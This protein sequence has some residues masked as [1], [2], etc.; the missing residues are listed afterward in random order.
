LPASSLGVKLLSFFIGCVHFR[1]PT[2]SSLL[3]NGFNPGV[4]LSKFNIISD[5]PIQPRDMQWQYFVEA[6]S[7]KPEG[8]GFVSG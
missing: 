8:C 7:Y 5:V 2:L 6:L 3:L 4:S 1:H